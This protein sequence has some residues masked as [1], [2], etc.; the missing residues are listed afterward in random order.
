MAGHNGWH[1]ALFLIEYGRFD[2]VLADYDRFSAP[3]LAG[4]ATLDRIDAASLLWRLELAGV[5]VGNRWAPV[6]DKW[7]AHVD[8]HVLAF[9]DLH[10]AFA[11]AR[12]PDPDDVLRFRRSL[13]AHERLGS[14]DNR[15]VTIEVGRKLIDGS[16]AFAGGDAARAVEAILPVRSEA[17]RIGGS[18]AQR[19]IVNLTLIAAAERSGQWSLARTLLAE[20]ADVRPTPRTKAQYHRALRRAPH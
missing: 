13:E 11:A 15:Q 3:K 17:V 18:H 14:G 4:D 2:E 10:C 12:S 19:D 7:M 20:R 8:D 16:L 6:A 9:N 1:L 5:D